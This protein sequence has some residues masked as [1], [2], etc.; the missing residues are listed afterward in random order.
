MSKI[1]QSYPL[2]LSAVLSNWLVNNYRAASYAHTVPRCALRI[3]N[4][5]AFVL[6]KNLILVRP[7][8][9][10][11]Q[12]VRLLAGGHIETRELRSC[13]FESAWS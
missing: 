12:E 4:S 5:G 6:V 3:R 11:S 7:G 1:A 8:V 9:K 13:H 10:D 2:K